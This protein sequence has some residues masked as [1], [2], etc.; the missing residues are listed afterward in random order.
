MPVP[1]ERIISTDS[2]YYRECVGSLASDCTGFF[3]VSDTTNPG[4][5]SGYSSVGDTETVSLSS[6]CTDVGN[7]VR[8]P[9][10]SG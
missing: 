2:N 8:D 4:L 1:P 9:S 6:V 10:I 5:P 3:S 7:G